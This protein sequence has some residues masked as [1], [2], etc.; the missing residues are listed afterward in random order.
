MFFR[1]V[2]LLGKIC[3]RFVVENISF[4]KFYRGKKINFSGL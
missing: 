4:V 2:E 3:F 1:Y